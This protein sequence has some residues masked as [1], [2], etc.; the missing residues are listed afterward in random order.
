MISAPR[1]APSPLTEGAKGGV[2]WRL[3]T[4]PLAGTLYALGVVSHCKGHEIAYCS[5][6]VQWLAAR[7]VVP[8]VIPHRCWLR[9]CV[10][11]SLDT[12]W[13]GPAQPISYQLWA[14]TYTCSKPSP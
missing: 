6:L 5:I 4:C 7:R 9:L 3:S 10:S 13:P 12:V 11:V 2:W 1:L 14:K 8:R